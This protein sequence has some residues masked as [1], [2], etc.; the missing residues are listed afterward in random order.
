MPT[1]PSPRHAARRSLF[2]S[3]IGLRL[4]LAAPRGEF[5]QGYQ[6]VAL[7]VL[8]RYDADFADL[9]QVIRGEKSLAWSPAHDLA[10]QETIL[11]ASGMPVA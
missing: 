10:V 5:K 9:A 6:D 8:P 1:I 7:P 3:G 2:Q 4:A 11:R